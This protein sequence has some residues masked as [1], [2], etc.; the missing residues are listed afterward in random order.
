MA[1]DVSA[2]GPKPTLGFRQSSGLL[3][4][5]GEIESEASVVRL[6]E[7]VREQPLAISPANGRGSLIDVFV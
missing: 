7:E 2:L 3:A 5:K 6:V 1:T 4:L